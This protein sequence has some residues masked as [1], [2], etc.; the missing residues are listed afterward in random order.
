MNESFMQILINYK[1]EIKRI[2][3]ISKNENWTIHKLYEELEKS[4]KD[5][6]NFVS[7]YEHMK[8]TKKQFEYLTL[9]IINSLSPQ[10]KSNNNLLSSNSF[11]NFNLNEK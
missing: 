2:I 9:D 1:S 4:N 8:Y 7:S 5:I 6:D 11:T 10:Q 3:N